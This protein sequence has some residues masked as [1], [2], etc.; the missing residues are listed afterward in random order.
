[1]YLSRRLSLPS[2]Q[3]YLSVLAHLQVLLYK[4][5]IAMGM[6]LGETI[7]LVQSRTQKDVMHVYTC[8]YMS[9]V[10]SATT[11]GQFVLKTVVQ[12]VAT[13]LTGRI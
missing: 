2:R 9:D 8:I 1:M 12:G 13:V 5:F 4:H 6:S 10:Q 11:M 7:W 3:S